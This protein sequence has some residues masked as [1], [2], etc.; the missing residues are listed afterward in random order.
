[1]NNAQSLRALA[2]IHKAVKLRALRDAVKELGK[3]PDSVDDNLDV[4]QTIGPL[5]DQL[6]QH[7]MEELTAALDQEQRCITDQMKNWYVAVQVH[8]TLEAAAEALSKE[9]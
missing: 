9:D 3:D 1:M 4:L 2:V 7:V 8:G 6:G 5:N